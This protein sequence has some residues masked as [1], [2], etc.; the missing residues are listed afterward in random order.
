MAC[1][2]RVHHRLAR[3]RRWSGN[4][5]DHH[6]QKDQRPGHRV[7]KDRRPGAA[8]TA[9]G[10]GRDSRSVAHLAAPSAG[11]L[12]MSCSTGSSHQRRLGAAADPSGVPS[13]NWNTFSTPSPLA[14]LIKATGAPAASTSSADSTS[15]AAAMQI[16]RHVQDHQR[17]QSQAQNRSSQQQMPAQIR[18]NP[19]STAPRPA[20]ERP[21]SVPAEHRA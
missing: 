21:S 20:W 5:R 4:T 3:R 13:R 8:S 14:A 19:G 9:A 18:A 11:T 1:G 2:N 10:P 16:V 12:G 6:C 7:Q 17:R 15:A